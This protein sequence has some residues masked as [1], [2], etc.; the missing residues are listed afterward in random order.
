MYIESVPNRNSPPAILLREGWREGG[1]VKK[2]TIANLSDWPAQK[3]EAL[4][5]VLKGAPAGLG[6]DSFD[7]IRSRPH[8]HVAAALGT[9][10]RLGLPALLSRQP[11]RMR[12]IVLALTVSRIM[13]PGSKL[14]TARSLGAESGSSSLGTLLDLEHIDED[15]IYEAMDWLLP[16][17]QRIEG[18]LAR[19]HLSNGTLV[20]YDLTSTYFEGR[21]C[22]LAAL[23]HSRDGKRGKLQIT[24]GLL[25]EP[26][27]RPVAV[28]VFAGNTGDPSTVGSQIE[29]L[30][31]R[32]G[33]ER[34]VL[35]GDRG[36]ITEA[37]IREEIAPVA[38]LDWISALRSPQIQALVEHGSLQLSL[39]DDKDLGEIRDPRYPGERLIACRNP[40]L[41]QER[42]R[43]RQEL[44]SATERELDKIVAATVRANR[45]L[46]G[47]AKIGQRVG[48]VINKYK[49]GKHFEVEIT[50]TSMTYQRKHEQIE[51][52]AALDG[53]YVIRTSVPETV[54]NAKDTVRSYK[55]LS[56]VERAF[57]TFKTVDL[58]VRPIFHHLEDRVRSHVFVCMLAYYV[59]WHMRHDLAPMLFDDHH[60]DAG[61]ALRTSVVARAQR[62]PQ[63]MRKVLTKRTDEGFPVHSFRTLLADLATV[64]LSTC[65]TQVDGAPTFVKITTPTPVQHRAFD[66]LGVSPNL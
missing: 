59:E 14:A 5:A 53:I 65:R 31:K 60:P 7:I 61:E 44:L 37:R 63:A 54:L 47:A 20:L 38:G 25:C 66:L 51:T 64:A 12:D 27:G 57:R 36:M 28:E 11:S 13:D 48:K 8:G 35:V 55:S 40:F 43:K 46:K 41:A 3:I 23:G 42:S 22:S 6:A 2:R 52:E 17:Q 16:E 50:D 21:H 62:S 30:R 32:F 45:A 19:R 29:K 10:R 18:R 24:V 33:L 34:V 1:K 9:A 4:R 39:F 15:D 56:R 58:K 49:V 26:E